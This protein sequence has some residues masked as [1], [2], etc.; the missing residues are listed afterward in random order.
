[1]SLPPL[2]QAADVATALGVSGVGVLPSTMQ[3]RMEPTLAKVSRRW[4]KEAQRQFTPGT[5]THRLQIHGG[6]VRLAEQPNKVISVRVR[7]LKQLD[8]YDA[9]NEGGEDWAIWEAG[10]DPGGFIQTPGGIDNVAS[11]PPVENHPAPRWHV[12]GCWLR[13]SDWDFWRLNG[14]TAEVTYSWATPVPDDVV[15]AVADI[16]GRVLSVDPMSALRQSTLLMSRH[17]RQQVAP[18][19][20]NGDTGFT[21]DDIAQARSYRYPA[22]PI[23]IAALSSVDISPAE[24]F[25]SDSS[26]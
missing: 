26:W 17:F 18:W 20:A 21:D 3:I 14:L 5:Y 12:E 4:R 9:F 8:R 23:I 1:M 19:V 22:P 10:G 16:T 11:P 15:A 13:W 6:A 25:L 7:G 2:A 24:A